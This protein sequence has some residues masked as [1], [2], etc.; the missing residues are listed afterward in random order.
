MSLK[1]AVTSKSFSNNFELIEELNKYFSDVKL[2]KEGKKFSEK[3]LIEFFKDVDGAIVGLDQINKNVLK[4]SPQ[5]KV[6]SKYGVGLNNIDLLAC[7][8]NDISVLFSKGVNKLSVAEMTLSN[9]ISL[10][11]NIF[12]T[13]NQLKNGKWNKSGG[14]QLSGKKVGVVGVGNIGKELIRLLK[15]FNCEIYVN[16]INEQNDFYKQHELIE[17]SK[18]FIYKTCDFISI[19]TPLDNTTENLITTKE[20]NLMKNT[21]IVINSARGGIV[22]E[23]DLKKALINGS[24]GGAAIDSYVEEPCTDKELLRIENLITTPHIGGNSKEAVMA[25]GLSAIN[26]LKEFYL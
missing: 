22:N 6:I 11:R 5:L 17:S 3:E 24:I 25:M 2:N 8:E 1:I 23:A 15:P 13:T 4:N 19:H 20:F 9:M 7:E 14:F 21:C 12:V 18:E 10:S 16:D 26:N